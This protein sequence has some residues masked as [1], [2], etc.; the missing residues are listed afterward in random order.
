MRNQYP[1]AA[2][3]HVQNLR[4]GSAAKPSIDGAE[5]IDGRLA[6]PNP[7]NNRYIQI[8]IRNETNA[9]DWRSL[10]AARAR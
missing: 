5:K 1:S 10:I 7:F 4:I 6:K 9:H 2:R 8:G 3:R